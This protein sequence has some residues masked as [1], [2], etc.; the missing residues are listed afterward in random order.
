MNTVQ[1]AA[2]APA[3][4]LHGRGKFLANQEAMFLDKV[5]ALLC[6]CRQNEGT[7]REERNESIHES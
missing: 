2:N 6:R 4:C 3:G 7:E 5:R 1:R